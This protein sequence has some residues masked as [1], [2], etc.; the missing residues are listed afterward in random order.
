MASLN[1]CPRVLRVVK[2]HQRKGKQK[3]ESEDC[4]T[5]QDGIQQALPGWIIWTLHLPTAQKVSVASVSMIA[6]T[7]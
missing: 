3:D 5:S 4:S 1:I 2:I 7:V 6:R